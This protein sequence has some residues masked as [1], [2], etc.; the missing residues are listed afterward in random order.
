MSIPPP[1]DSS[2]SIIKVLTATG[3]NTWNDNIIKM[4]IIGLS[5]HVVTASWGKDVT[6]LMSIL[7]MLPYVL[8][9]PFA[10]FLSDHFC[11]A[12]IIRSMMFIQTILLTA[13]GAVIYWNRGEQTLVIL[14]ILF[15]LIAI[16]A[17]LFSPAKMGIIK[18]LVGSQRLTQA[19]SQLQMITQIGIL[20]GMTLGGYWFDF[21]YSR[22]GDPW[23]AALIPLYFLISL[24]AITTVYVW[25]LRSSEGDHAISSFRFSLLF[26]HFNPLRDIY[27]SPQLRRAFLGNAVYWFIGCAATVMFFDIG[28]AEHFLKSSSNQFILGATS[29]SSLMTC[30][31]GIGTI[32]SCSILATLFKK[33]NPLGLLPIGSLGLALTLLITG[34]LSSHHLSYYLSLI[35]VGFFGGCYLVPLLT[36]I[37]D[38]VDKDKRGIVLSSMNL[39]DSIAG[40]LGVLLIFILKKLSIPFFWQYFSLSL[41]IAITG[42]YILTL[43]P[44]SFIRLLVLSFVRFFY[45]L[46]VLHADRLPKENG[47][48]LLPNHVSY[49]DALILSA[50]CPRPIRFVIWDELYHLPMLNWFLRLVNVVPISKSR[51]KD[52][53][54]IVSEAL[55]NGE[56]VCLFPE[57]QI[58]RHGLLNEIRK[59]FEIMARH[60]NAFV[61]P[62]YIDGLFGSIF[63][64][65]SNRVFWKKPRQW[66]YPVIVVYGHPLESDQTNANS[67]RIQLTQLNA[68]GM[69]HRLNCIQSTNLHD[70]HHQHQLMRL[71]ELDWTQPNDILW[72]DPQLRY[73]FEWTLQ[74]YSRIV[75]HCHYTQ[76]LNTPLPQN[77]YVLILKDLK[78]YQ[79][80]L[81]QNSDLLSQVRCIY[82]WSSPDQFHLLNVIPQPYFFWWLDP[83]T[84]LI[85]TA[86]FPL[87][88]LA[89]QT[90]EPQITHK[91]Q[92][93][94]KLLNG[95]TW[96]QHDDQLIINPH[97]HHHTISL[98][99]HLIDTQNFIIPTPTTPIQ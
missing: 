5:S 39:I 66:P 70:A 14:L 16:Q 21:E 41:L 87:Q 30:S 60:A 69:S 73:S 2:N 37:Q 24:A 22:H 34:T 29:A 67:V 42:I 33:E 90:D 19:N 52:A 28:N 95:Y 78:S 86:S 82:F 1:K 72:L 49:V 36:Y 85:I 62:I 99:A 98:P 48:L 23:R 55:K 93:L 20:A 94:G 75:G 38:H 92:S 18:E 26:S 12:K 7:I 89:N 10:G 53:I 76:S 80:L 45:K 74:R 51:A 97:F 65:A 35:A 40:V 4:L 47:V 83:S 6:A 46:D 27:R 25:N 84:Q 31:V 88:S 61:Q 43:L 54:K 8:L 15:A 3:V 57:G 44:Q 50:A 63:S 58:S 81:L 77:P 71:L 96:T 91:D 9:A 32:L 68:E 17:T 11:K 56:I 64:F 79:E 13:I 59:G